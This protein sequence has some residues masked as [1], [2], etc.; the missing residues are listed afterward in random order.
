MNT[1]Y[2]Q[3][4]LCHKKVKL[5]NI[6][7][8]LRCRSRMNE[9]RIL[10]QN[11]SSCGCCFVL[12]DLHPPFSPWS[13]FLTCLCT[14]DLV[15]FIQMKKCSVFFFFLCLAHFTQHTV[16]GYVHVVTVPSFVFVFVFYHINK[17]WWSLDRC[18]C[19]GNQY[20]DYSQCENKLSYNL[21]YPLS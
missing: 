21:V 6:S 8:Y 12:F 13:L 20:R 1:I 16:F 19:C 10:T 3:K 14:F 11:G 15:L 9:L 5:T 7:I 4:F 17:F 18:S 2:K